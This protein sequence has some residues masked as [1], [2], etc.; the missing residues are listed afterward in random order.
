MSAVSELAMSI[1]FLPEHF[2]VCLSCEL[3][4]SCYVARDAFHSGR[5]PSFSDHN[6]NYRFPRDESRFLYKPGGLFSMKVRP[7]VDL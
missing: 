5:Q 2:R 4:N 7:L 6:V 3:S 1:L